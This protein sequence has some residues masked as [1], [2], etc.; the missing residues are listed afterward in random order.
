VNPSGEKVAMSEYSAG[1]FRAKKK[2]LGWGSVIGFA[3]VMLSLL[4][5][6]P[7]VFVVVLG[8]IAVIF[9]FLTPAEPFELSQSRHNE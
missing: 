2:Q 1:V 5:G 7:P 8:C 9:L 3:I 6:L 4:S